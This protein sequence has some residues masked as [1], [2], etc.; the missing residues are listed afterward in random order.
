MRRLD[1]IGLYFL[2]NIFGIL[3]VADSNKVFKLDPWVI[4]E[5]WLPSM[6]C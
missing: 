4:D 5:Y 2:P 6:F 3:N 1:L